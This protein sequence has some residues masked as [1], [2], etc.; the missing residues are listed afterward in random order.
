[1]AV[2]GLLL[3]SGCQGLGGSTPTPSTTQD[4]SAGTGAW[5]NLAIGCETVEPEPNGTF[6][7]YVAGGGNFQGE[8]YG[9]SLLFLNEGPC[10]D[11]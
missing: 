2:V 8:I 11:A 4:Q 9:V 6:R 3:V 5:W 10:L 7:G 1:M